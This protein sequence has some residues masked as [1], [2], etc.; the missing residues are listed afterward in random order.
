MNIFGMPLDIC[1]QALRNKAVFSYLF[2]K[3]SNVFN[4]FFLYLEVQ[5]SGY[6]LNYPSLKQIS[7]TNFLC[8]INEKQDCPNDGNIYPVHNHV[9]FKW[10]STPVGV[11]YHLNWTC[12]Q[13]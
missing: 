10:F 13:G 6:S 3:S 8:G 11:W 1:T 2:T 9:Q 5:Y 4:F 7:Q 12:G